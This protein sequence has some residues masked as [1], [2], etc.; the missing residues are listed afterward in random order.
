MKNKIAQLLFLV[1][2]ISVFAENQD[3]INARQL[4]ENGFW[5]ESLVELKKVPKSQKNSDY[6]LLEAFAKVM[7][8]Q[9]SAKD[10]KYILNNASLENKLILLLKKQQY[11][12]AISYGEKALTETKLSENEKYLLGLAYLGTE[13]YDKAESFLGTD[14]VFALFY[15]AYCQYVLGK[16][17]ESY[18]NFVK[19]TKNYPAHR[20]GIESHIYAAKCCIFN[21][22]FENAIREGKFAVNKATDL[23]QKIEA[24]LL[25][26]NLY[27]EQN[28][29]DEAISLLTSISSTYNE[30]NIPVKFKIAEIYSLQGKI[31]EANLIYEDIQNF[32]SG[33]VYA[34][35]AA[36]KRGKM[37]FDNEQYFPAK[38]H[39]TYCESNF[40]KGNFAEQALYYNAVSRENLGEIDEAVL[41][42]LKIISLYE[43]S[44]YVF[45][46]HERL[47]FLFYENG[48][49]N[50]ALSEISFL[51]ENYTEQVAFSTVNNLKPQLELLI[52]GEDEDMVDLLQ[53]WNKNKK[54]E[55]L[56]GMN[57]GIQLAEKYLVSVEEKEK[58]VDILNQ[59]LA[60]ISENTTSYEK[61]K[62]AAKAN[63]LLGLYN[64]I[65]ADYVLGSEYYLKSASFYMG[66]SAESAAESMYKAA[67]A[68]SNARKSKDV[69]L[70]YNKMSTLYPNSTWT[71]KTGL[72]LENKSKN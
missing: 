2:C 21:N 53:Q 19:V 45:S 31:S 51:Q 12:E 72:I 11:D 22:D 69:E 3:F 27:Q 25:V 71:E 37:Y 43:N 13:K 58:G 20:L 68:L 24:A 46:A 35:E 57:V 48:E 56:D 52:S 16:T 18:E 62:V 50:R 38:N 29:S 63:T 64:C 47:A 66:I 30:K 10:E 42:Y 61:A 17:S 15:T 32:Y 70:V 6:Q 41:Q 9:A 26:A 55:T 36:F 7:T 5:N 8:N 33:T 14:S 60:K 54:A 34:E 23:S 28:K 67:L 59:I 49:Y 65:N 40:P 4:A 44:Y 1:F 39:F